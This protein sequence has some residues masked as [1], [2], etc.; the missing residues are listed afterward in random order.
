[1]PKKEW[2]ESLWKWIERVAERVEAEVWVLSF[3]EDVFPLQI[4]KGMVGEISRGDRPSRI[5][6]WDEDPRL[7]EELEKKIHPLSGETSPSASRHVHSSLSVPIQIQGKNAG[8]LE[9]INKKGGGSFT[10][11]DLAFLSPVGDFISLLL[12]NRLLLV[13]YERKVE[14]F[15]LLYEVGRALSS[16]LD[17]TELLE[18]SAHLIRVQFNYYYVS[19]FL[20]EGDENRLLLRGFSGTRGVEPMRRSIGIGSEGIIGWSTRTGE[21]LVVPD[22]SQEERYIKGIEGIQ[23]EMVIPIKREKEIL[24][25]LDIGSDQKN[26]FKEEDLRTMN[27]LTRQLAIAIENA[28][29]VQRVEELAITDDLTHL[30]NTRYCNLYLEKLVSRG[31]RVSIIFLDIDFFKRVDDRY[32]HRIGAF[33]LREVAKRLKEWVREGDVCFRYCGD[34]YVII[35]PNTPLEEAVRLAGKLKRSFEERIFMI[36]DRFPISLT[37]SFGVATYPDCASSPWDL[38]VKADQAMYRV[39][40]SGR[41]NVEV[42][43]KI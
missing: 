11:E 20:R 2:K 37:A 29:L 17:L 14:E 33:T 24:G 41:N 27:L 1:M 22:V 32:G 15:S 4:G 25:V 8:I 21:S 31:E 7:Y 5:V 9:V 26:T 18:R 38:L 34:E 40:E 23:S 3:Q 43:K 30:Y 13:N 35:L 19:I 6:D 10:E 39:K 16:I 28:R 36:E 42:A 12:E